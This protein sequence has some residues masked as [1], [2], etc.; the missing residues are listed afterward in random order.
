MVTQQIV[1][2]TT[3][4]ELES[5]D[6]T[7]LVKVRNTGYT[8]TPFGLGRDVIT[9]PIA[10]KSPADDA[11]ANAGNRSDARSDFITLTMALVKKTDGNL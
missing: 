10:K 6:R 9:E 7:G 2:K 5:K 3:K 8:T 4:M 1:A 11:I